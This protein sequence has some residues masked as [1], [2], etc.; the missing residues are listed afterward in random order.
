MN[1]IES[2]KYK[3]NNLNIL[4]KL[5]VFNVAIFLFVFIFKRFITGVLTYLVLPPDF[6]D[7]LLQPWAIITYSFLHYKLLHLAFNMLWLYFCGR[8]FMNLFSPKMAINIYFLGAISGGLAYLLFFNLFPDYFATKYFPLIGASAAVRALFIFLCTYMPNNEVRLINWNIKIWHI[9]A[10]L[11]L[12][13]V[14]GLFGS[15]GGGSLAHLGGALLGYIYAK[16]IVKGNDI[17]KGFERTVDTASGWFKSGKKGKLKTVH[18][19][20]TKVGGFTKG[21]FE[22]FNN[23]KKIDVILDKISKSGYESL[24]AAEKEFLFKVGK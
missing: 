6:Y 18:K 14:I 8:L 21:E 4:E 10:V 22:E 16:Q 20:K 15:N 17:G 2:L 3:F 9:G 5:I 24:T 19:D 13:D 1:Q 11:I 23:Q 7:A 12:F